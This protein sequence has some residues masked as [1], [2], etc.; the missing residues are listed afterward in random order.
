[1]CAF[2]WGVDEYEWLFHDPV[3][4]LDYVGDSCFLGVSRVVIEGRLD[5]SCRSKVYILVEDMK[6]AKRTPE[7]VAGHSLPC[8]LYFFFPFLDHH[9]HLPTL[10]SRSSTAVVR[11]Q[12]GE[13]LQLGGGTAIGLGER[14]VQRIPSIQSITIQLRYMNV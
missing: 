8:L 6:L 13:G 10:Q 12:G 3:F 4:L 9:H 14:F 5:E 11:A 1:M 2:Q 7:D